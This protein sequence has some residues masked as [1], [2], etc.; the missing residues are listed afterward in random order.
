M[1]EDAETWVLNEDKICRSDRIYRLK[2]IIKEYPAI[3][4]E[5]HSGDRKSKYLFE[6]ARYCFVYA[7]F[8]AATMLSLSYIENM[9]GSY[10]F[11]ID[12]IRNDKI[13]SIDLLKKARSLGILFEEE[14]EL[15]NK[16]RRIRNP[17][18]HYRKYGREDDFNQ[19][20]LK[21]RKHPYEILEKDSKMALKAVFRLLEKFSNYLI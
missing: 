3:Y 2:W 9:L 11:A 19:R 5:K 16:I 15:F 21:E 8:I 17:L 7:Q 10:L 6:E 13:R 18:V 12:E 4:F 14:Y 20:A 1:V